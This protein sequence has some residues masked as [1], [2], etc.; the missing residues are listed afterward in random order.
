MYMKGLGGLA[1]D[2][3]VEASL[4]R[5]FGSWLKIARLELEG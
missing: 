3:Y 5:A 1:V 4:R 2:G